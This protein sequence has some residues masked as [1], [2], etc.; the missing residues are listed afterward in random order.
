MTTKDERRLRDE[1][2]QWIDTAG[3]FHVEIDPQRYVTADPRMLA[4]LRAQLVELQTTVLQVI[5]GDEPHG[6]CPACFDELL[7]DVSEATPQVSDRDQRRVVVATIDAISGNIAEID[8]WVTEQRTLRSSGGTS[9][10]LVPDELDGWF[11]EAVGV[12]THIAESVA[13]EKRLM[14]HGSRQSHRGG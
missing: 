10:M 11:T 6:P 9:Y 12:L 14:A 2:R 5:R 13:I 1:V 4:R 8:D 3:T 7:R